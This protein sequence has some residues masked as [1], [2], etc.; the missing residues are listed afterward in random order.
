[1]VGALSAK[2]NKTILQTSTIKTT[3]EAVELG[4]SQAAEKALHL[5]T[6]MRTAL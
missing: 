5:S 3:A 1:M 2:T 6:T 4:T